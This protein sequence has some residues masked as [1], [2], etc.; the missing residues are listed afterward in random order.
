MEKKYF[1]GL[2]RTRNIIFLLNRKLLIILKNAYLKVRLLDAY[3]GILIK[4]PC[5]HVWQTQ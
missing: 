4:K 3:L 5:M 1:P 2:F